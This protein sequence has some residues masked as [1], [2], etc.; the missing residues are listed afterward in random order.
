M[1]DADREEL[2]R[3]AL[4]N[5]GI[6]EA[7]CSFDKLGE[8]AS[9]FPFEA[10]SGPTMRWH[11]GIVLRLVN[12]CDSV[13]DFG[14]GDG[15]LLYRLSL[16]RNCW[17]QGIES[18]EEMVGRC[19][20]RGIPVCHGD[21]ID[22]IDL[23]P[24]KSYTWGVLEDTLTML[25]NPLDA[26]N[27]MLRVA[28]ACIVSFPNFAHW[29]MR[30]TFSLGGRMPVTKSFPYKWYDTPN[31]HNCSINDFMD[32]IASEHITVIEAWVLVDGNVEKYDA[33]K[34]HN[35]TASQ[36]LFVVKGRD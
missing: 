10:E 27:R 24:D 16:C 6:H 9:A 26:L 12:D 28:D 32:W 25:K 1:K 20:E 19:I 36:A 33:A 21:M 22:I 34:D 7:D 15:E 29:S 8:C 14:C 2:Y 4:A 23:I 13:I 17:M 11:D 35:I 31:I 3:E 5:L 30:F 18:D